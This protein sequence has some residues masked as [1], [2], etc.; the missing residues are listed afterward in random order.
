MPCKD[1]T[2]DHK[3]NVVAFEHLLDDFKKDVQEDDLTHLEEILSL[4][5]LSMDPPAGAFKQ[6]KKRSLKNYENRCLHQH[7]FDCTVLRKIV[8][9]FNLE[10]LLT[11]ELY[12]NNWVL[13]AKKMK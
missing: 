11:D 2:F 12:L 6:F 3:R 13:I 4:H 7:V 5:D 1:F 9:H 8:E 10:V